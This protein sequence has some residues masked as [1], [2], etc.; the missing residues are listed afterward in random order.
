MSA[1]IENSHTSISALV[2]HCSDIYRRRVYLQ[3]TFRVFSPLGQLMKRK[4]QVFF[5]VF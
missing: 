2:T 3:T 5:H 1:S 4:Q